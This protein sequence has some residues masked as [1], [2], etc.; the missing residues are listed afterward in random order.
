VEL[1]RWDE[2]QLVQRCKDGSEAAYAELVR[3]Y[4]PRLF[5]L[6]YRL[7]SDRGAAEDVVQETF[8]AAF[9][10]LDRFEPRPS[11]SAWLNTILIRLAGRSATRAESRPRR[12]LDAMLALEGGNDGMAM[13][14]GAAPSDDPHAAAETAE[15]R[16]ELARAIASLPFKYRAAVVTRFILGLDYGEAAATLEL[17]LNTYKSH[18]LRGTRILRT[19]LMDAVEG[20]GDAGAP[21]T[22]PQEPH[23]RSAPRP[24]TADGGQVFEPVAA[25]T[26]V[27]AGH[28]TSG[29]E[30]IRRPIE[31]PGRAERR[32][33]AE[34][35]ARLQSTAGGGFA[36]SRSPRFVDRLPGEGPLRG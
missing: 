24:A 21:L 10:A 34:S 11:L 26:V 1:A 8:V 23:P 25:V 14:G 27:P 15:L 18:L 13:V 5:T 6:A 17:G 22:R 2:Q 28:R 3:R 16:L 4:R 19:L 29:A 31:R 12:S 7:T 9:R 30:P 20:R 36:E 32:V 35:P 33:G